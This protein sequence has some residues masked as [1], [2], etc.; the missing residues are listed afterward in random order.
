MLVSN[1]TA[2]N[3]D[4][5][6]LTPGAQPKLDMIE[7]ALEYAMPFYYTENAYVLR[8]KIETLL[9]CSNDVI[10]V[11][12]VG[13]GYSGVEVSTNIADFLGQSRGSVTLVDRNARVLSTSPEHNRKT[14]EK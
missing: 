1:K 9:A 2:L 12:V 5:L 6:V 7:G 13:A 8:N 3:Y 14:A 4:F 10:R 11:V